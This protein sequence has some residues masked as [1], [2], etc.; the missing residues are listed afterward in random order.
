MTVPILP[1]QNKLYP[2]TR[3]MGCK[4]KLL[5]NIHEIVNGLDFDTAIDAFSGSGVVSYMFKTLGKNVIAND[6]MH[7]SLTFAKPPRHQ[8]CYRP[9]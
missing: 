4:K 3:F 8:H 5:P 2:R 6:H 7:M 1:E 9:A